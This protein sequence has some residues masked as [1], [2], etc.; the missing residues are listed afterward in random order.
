M[1][2]YI[3]LCIGIIFFAGFF[4]LYH[5]QYGDPIGD[6]ADYGF[7][8]I[9]Y[10]DYESSPYHSTP[11]EWFPTDQAPAWLKLSFHDAP[12]LFF[13]VQHVSFRAFGTNTFALRFPS[14]VFG[15][16]TVVLTIILATLLYNK[17]VGIL[18]GIFLA[19]SSNAIYVS[20]VGHLES[21]TIFFIL[22]TI[23]LYRLALHN[24]TYFIPMGVALGLGLMTKY[25]AVIA[26]I[27]ILC[28]A[29]F[30]FRRIFRDKLFWIGILFA[31]LIFSPVI[32]YNIMLYINFGHFDY[33]LMNLIGPIPEVWNFNPGREIGTIPERIRSFIPQMFWSGSWIII[34]T[35]YFSLGYIFV[36]LL[37]HPRTVFQRHRFILISYILLISYVIVL[38]PAPRFLAM[39]KPFFA[40]ASG[41]VFYR[42]LFQTSTKR[43]AELSIIVIILLSIVY[44]SNTFL[45]PEPIG[46]QY[47]TFSPVHY[48]QED[49][50]YTALDNYFRKEFNGR[51][52]ALTRKQQHEF[53]DKI[54]AEWVQEKLQQNYSFY[55]AVIVYDPLMQPQATLFVLGRRLTYRGWPVMSV[56]RFAEL[57][58]KTGGVPNGTTFYYIGLNPGAYIKTRF[59]KPFDDKGQ[60]LELRLTELGIKPQI[61]VDQSGKPSFQIYK[62]DSK[63][64]ILWELPMFVQAPDENKG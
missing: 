52:P 11:L 47:L 7:R 42:L 33:A 13:F 22:L 19:L 21:M 3:L 8:S 58:K 25:T 35:T 32:V 48:N 14:A 31:G 26:L 38:G 5:L 17:P 43:P 30:F 45:A 10:L 46:H 15:I 37:Q 20:R 39:L 62:W 36:R 50:G 24:R 59:M 49:L 6:E 55:P 16:G 41:V 2:T 63:E 4:R 44:N 9:G 27:L 64:K 23:V 61:I 40:M 60:H 53:L 56:D 29:L 51:I 57:Q 12:P 28:N 34:L 54:A 18:A 1:K